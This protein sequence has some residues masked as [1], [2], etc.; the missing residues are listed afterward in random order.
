M[1]T[2]NIVKDTLDYL[3][4]KEDDNS[5]DRFEIRITYDCYI[6]EISLNNHHCERR[7]SHEE[8]EYST[9]ENMLLTHT[10]I[11]LISLS[12]TDMIGV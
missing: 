3:I 1:T 10:E 9:L 6:I 8:I 12:N 11:L 2:K 7:I 4:S 5:I